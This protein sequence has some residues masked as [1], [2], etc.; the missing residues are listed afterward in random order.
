[1]STKLH[2]RLIASNGTR[3]KGY[4]RKKSGTRCCIFRLRTP[5]AH[6]PS[7]HLPKK[8]IMYGSI[9]ARPGSWGLCYVRHPAANQL[10][11]SYFS[12]RHLLH[13]SKQ[14]Q[15][16]FSFSNTLWHDKWYCVS[17]ISREFNH[18]EISIQ[19]T[20]K[21]CSETTERRIS[22]SATSALHP[23]SSQTF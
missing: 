14:N 1:M 6:P 11:T 5:E 21:A 17:V 4:G 12:P 10:Q 3:N 13:S 23:S 19:L 8:A 22:L 7:P 16:A 2:C 18:L 9:R 20:V 15:P